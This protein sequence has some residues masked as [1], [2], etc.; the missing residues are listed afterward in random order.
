MREF[1]TAYSEFSNSCLPWT[2]HDYS[3]L[4]YWDDL[5]T[6]AQP[7]CA[8][9]PGG[10]CGIYTSITGSAP[11]RIFNLEWRAVYFD[12]V[13]TTANFELRLYEGQNRF[14]VIYGS[15]AGG[16]TSASPPACIRTTPTLTN[17]SATA[18]AEQQ[19]AG[20][21]TCCKGVERR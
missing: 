4:P 3:I 7:G 6:D 11:D 12:S 15:V 9:F 14:D 21:A 10:T 20:K 18:R 16:N 1:V 19:R 8:A 17:T 5:M 2:G 13:M